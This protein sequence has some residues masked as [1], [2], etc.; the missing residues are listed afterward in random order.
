MSIC[1]DAG[2]WKPSFVGGLRAEDWCCCYY[3]SRQGKPTRSC[4]VL[5]TEQHVTTAKPPSICTRPTSACHHQDYHQS[6][7]RSDEKQRPRRNRSYVLA[8][9]LS[10]GNDNGV[11]AFRSPVDTL[12]P[13]V[14]YG[15]LPALN[16]DNRRYKIGL[17]AMTTTSRQLGAVDQRLPEGGREKAG[18][19]KGRDRNDSTRCLNS[20]G[21]A[22]G[23]N[24]IDSDD[25][26]DGS[27]ID[28]DNNEL[29]CVYREDVVICG[30]L[31][32]G[33]C[34]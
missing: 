20:D 24:D 28:G 7:H 3:E 34:L 27:C 32:L 29:I 16:D 10:G 5:R 21:A 31:L 1:G 19:G 23:V 12:P 17:H 30:Y 26:D 11:A 15:V 4:V 9:L 13:S 8:M 18:E 6:E 33:G 22:D 14:Y 2:D 25:D